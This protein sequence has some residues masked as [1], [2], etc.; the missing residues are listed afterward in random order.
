MKVVCF[1]PHNLQD[2]YDTILHRNFNIFCSVDLV[3]QH[4]QKHTHTQR[5]LLHTVL[6]SFSLHSPAGGVNSTRDYIHPHPPLHPCVNNPPAAR[7]T[8]LLSPRSHL[9]V[10]GVFI[11]LE[12]VVD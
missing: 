4:V 3:Q 2:V 9:P 1:F 7:L 6:C 5:E 11:S 12:S 8:E 10:N